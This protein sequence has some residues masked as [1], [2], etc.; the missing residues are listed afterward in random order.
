[1]S[2]QQYNEKYNNDIKIQEEEKIQKNNILS[3]SDLSDSIDDS[4]SDDSD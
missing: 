1:M 3:N 2:I 4:S